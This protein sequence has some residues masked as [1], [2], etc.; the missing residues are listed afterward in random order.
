MAKVSPLRHLKM[1][2]EMYPAMSSWVRTCLEDKGKVGEADWPNW[3]FMPKAA[4]VALI[5]V[6]SMPVNQV[7][8]DWAVA[9]GVS[10]LSAIGT[11]RY[12]QGIYR[13]DAGLLTALADTDISGDLPSELFRRLPE[14]CVYIETPG[15]S[16][17][18]LDL[19]GFWVHLEWDFN[20]QHEELRFVLNTDQGLVLQPLHLGKWSVEEAID[21]TLAFSTANAKSD[22]VLRNFLALESLIKNSLVEELKPL[23]SILLYLCSDEPDFDPLRMPQAMPSRPVLRKGKRSLYLYTPEKARVFPVGNRVGPLLRNAIE[24]QV[25]GRTVKTHLRRGHWHGFW[26]GPR[27][28]VHNFIYHWI[29]PLVVEGKKP[30]E[31]VDT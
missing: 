2:I 14:W 24:A 4:W 27:K 23:I 16:W 29:A 9:E 10:V 1:V 17:F 11:W 19:H 8:P 28:G 3:C 7:E 22:S 12:S 18:D 15:L 31:V 6:K 25:S 30:S 26:K 13:F 20:H 21:R 5:Q